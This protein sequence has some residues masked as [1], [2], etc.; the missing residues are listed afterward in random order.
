MLLPQAVQYCINTLEAA[1]F[2]AYAVGGCVRDSLL[3]LVPADYDLCTNARPEETSRIFSRHQLLHHGQK[4]GTVGVVLDGQVFE[5]LNIPSPSCGA[6]LSNMAITP[7]G[8]VVPCQSWLS[9][10]PLG[11]MLADDWND[12]WDS[13]PC[14]NRRDFSAQLTGEC[15]LRRYC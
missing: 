4:H 11:N 7:G 13:E 8:N 2:Q 6:C 1:G 10:Q 3:G 5:E 14:R 15:P 9:G 12:I